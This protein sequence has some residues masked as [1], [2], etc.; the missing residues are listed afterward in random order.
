[1]EFWVE[2]G[3]YRRVVQVPRRLADYDPEGHPCDDAK[4]AACAA[5]TGP[6]TTKAVN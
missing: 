1:V 2:I 4:L 3:E 6:T 5:P